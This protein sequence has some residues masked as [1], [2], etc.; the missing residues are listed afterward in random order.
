MAPN[1]VEVDIAKL[2]RLRRG[3]GWSQAELARAAGLSGGTVVRVE[4]GHPCFAHTAASI[5]AA[6]GVAPEEIL[7]PSFAMPLVF[8]GEDLEQPGGLTAGMNLRIWRREGTP[9]GGEFL[10]ET[11]PLPLK[12]GDLVRIE[13]AVAPPAHAYL[14]W[15]DAQGQVKRL[16]PWVKPNGNCPPP[17]DRKIERIELPR[18][19]SEAESHAFAICGPAG[20]ETV[21]LLLS[22]PGP[23]SFDFS[24]GLPEFPRQEGLRTPRALA[25]FEYPDRAPPAV[26]TRGIGERTKKI[27]DPVFQIQAALRKQFGPHFTKILAISFPNQG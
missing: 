19:G 5:A 20:M 10:T 13:V 27:N 12:A 16:Y 9:P 4:G 6:L 14:L 17:D 26:R 25:R 8:A 7:E 1:T 23:T 22:Q 24:S 3:K 15:I 21:V 2:A 18:D 11:G